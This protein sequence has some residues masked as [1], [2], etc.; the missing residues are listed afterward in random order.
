MV[1]PPYRHT[2]ILYSGTVS[3]SMPI[4]VQIAAR[5]VESSRV[6]S[7]PAHCALR[8][9]VLGQ[10]EV[11]ACREAFKAFDTN[12]SGEIDAWELRDILKGLGRF[13]HA[14]IA[15]LK[16]TSFSQIARRAGTRP[17]KNFLS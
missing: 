4:M 10:A 6:E 17:T 1:V 12:E 11:E 15:I 3:T 13:V 14:N 5:G 8:T 2:T 16:R 7:P 9:M